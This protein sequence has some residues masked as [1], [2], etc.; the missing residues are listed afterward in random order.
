LLGREQLLAF[1]SIRWSLHTA[2]LSCSLWLWIK[3]CPVVGV[4][5][6]VWEIDRPAR[7]RKA[8]PSGTKHQSSSFILSPSPKALYHFTTSNW[9]FCRSRYCCG[10]CRDKNWFNVSTISWQRRLTTVFELWRLKSFWNVTW[11]HTDLIPCWGRI[12]HLS[13]KITPSPRPELCF[14]Q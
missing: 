13:G 1:Q 3:S 5:A 9:H 10:L 8:L 12:Y 14:Q 7:Q 6:C 4:I 2:E 11:G